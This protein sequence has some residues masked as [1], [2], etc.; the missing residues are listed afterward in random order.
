MI[1]RIFEIVAPI[2]FVVLVGYL[3]SRYKKP[4]MEAANSINLDVFVPIFIISV[5]ARQS[6]DVSQFSALILVG[7]V[8]TLLPGL[9]AFLFYRPFKVELKTLA[10]PLMFKNSG[11]LGIPL[12]LLTFGEEF[13]PAILILFVLENLLHFSFGLWILSPKY[14]SLVFLKQPMIV[15]LLS[16]FKTE[17]PVWLVTGLGML[18]DVAVPLML[19]ALGVRLVNLDLNGWRIGLFSAFAIPVCGL[20]AAALVIPFIPMDGELKKIAW[21]FAAL[22]PAILNFMLAEK[23][24]QQPDKVAAIVLFSN[25]GSILIIPCALYFI[26]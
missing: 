11:N 13:L 14:R 8:I 2:V 6:I 12:L 23:Y 5:F 9:A 1:V 16:F 4:N 7:T 17:L 20:L 24:N 15:L 25:I 3:Y 19:F 18:G 21:L 22:P 10:L 26:L